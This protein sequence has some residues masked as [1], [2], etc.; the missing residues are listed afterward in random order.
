MAGMTADT[1]RRAVLIALPLLLLGGYYFGFHGERTTRIA[2]LEQR[3]DKLEEQNRKARVLAAEGGPELE[4]RLALYQEHMTHLE[5]LIPTAEEVPRLL[6]AMSVN[7]R[8]SGVELALVKPEPETESA[9]Y[10]LQSYQ[11]GVIGQYHDVGRFLASIGSLPR[12]VTP[13]DLK[14]VPQNVRTGGDRV[15]ATFRIQTYVMP[16]PGPAVP[17]E[18]DAST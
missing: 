4:K 6:H 12:I 1:K 14:L 2:T 3:L 10:T 16:G 9:F 18:R 15:E 13:I 5:Q 8:E 11:V 17:T 7:A